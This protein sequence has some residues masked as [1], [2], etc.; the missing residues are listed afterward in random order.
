MWK[1]YKY[2]LLLFLDYLQIE[3]KIQIIPN[4]NKFLK[5][6]YNFKFNLKH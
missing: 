4:I 5:I 6:E 2:P 1:D 3:I